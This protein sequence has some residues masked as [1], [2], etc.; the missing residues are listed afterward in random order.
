MRVEPVRRA[1]S[2][3]I[4]VLVVALVV[5]SASAG[6]AAAGATPPIAGHQTETAQAT[7]IDSCTTIGQ[8]GR[9]VLTADIENA[10]Q[11]CIEITAD[12][13]FLDG[14]GHAIAGMDARFARHTGVRATA[15]EGV[16]VTNLTL[17][18][19]GFA[20]VYLRGVT[21]AQ[22]RNVTATGSRFGV[23]VRSA[24]GVRVVGVN[25]TNNSAAGVDVS[26]TNDAV[27]A[28]GTLADNRVG[29]S[30]TT[31]STDNR[32]VRN[33]V[34]NNR[35]GVVISNSDDNAVADNAFCGNREAFLVLERSRGNAFEDNRAC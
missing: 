2:A 14:A 28:D 29:V 31:T 7:E 3:S 21:D 32:V 5:S 20:G 34:R 15:A 9:Y 19:W 30:I 10:T 8:S 16:T 26:T 24:D 11:T 1:G 33:V 23:T 27:V 4:A 12:D 35:V 18:D 13:V 17:T 6:A 22:V 25:A